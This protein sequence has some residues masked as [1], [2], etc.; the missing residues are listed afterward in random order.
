MSAAIQDL[1]LI[2]QQWASTIHESHGVNPYL[3]IALTTVCA[4]P[5]YYSIYRLTK[6][7]ATKQTHQVSVWGSLFLGA[8]A[9]P[10]VYVLAFGRNMPWWIYL[11]LAALIAQG[12]LSLVRKLRRRTSHAGGRVTPNAPS[13]GYPVPVTSPTLA[14][15]AV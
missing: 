8:A 10:Y 5:F 1:V 4:P 15:A 7:L 6:A 12:I 13:T 9:L 2:L 3:Y 11:I 14:S